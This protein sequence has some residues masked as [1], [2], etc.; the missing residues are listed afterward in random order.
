MFE[1]LPLN[2]RDHIMH[3][4]AR[5]QYLTHTQQW[6]RYTKTG[7]STTIDEQSIIMLATRTVYLVLTGC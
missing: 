6:Y 5:V 4:N 7:V 3:N 1:Y 2:A